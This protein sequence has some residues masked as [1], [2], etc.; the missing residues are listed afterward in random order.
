MA[1]HK[2]LSKIQ[3]ICE[4]IKKI[5]KP[6][7]LIVKVGIGIRKITFSAK[8]HSRMYNCVIGIWTWIF[9]V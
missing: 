9:V 7:I 1:V 4:Y 6:I 8:G 5:F 3:F 2:E